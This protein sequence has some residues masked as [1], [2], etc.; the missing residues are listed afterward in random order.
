MSPRVLC[1][2]GDPELRATVREL[3]EASGF[4]VDESATALAGIERALTLPPDLVLADFHLPDIEGYQLATRLKQ[5]RSLARIPFVAVGTGAAEHDVA[6]AA[7][8]DGFIQQPI[9][10][11]RFVAEV[12]AFLAGKREQLDEQGE[13]AN[14]RTLSA[15][16]AARLERAVA[17]ASD[18][19]ARLDRSDKLKRAFIHNLAHELSTPLTPLAGY[20]KILQSGK[21]GALSDQQ[22]KILDSTL[23]AVGRLTRI[24][25]NLSDFASLQAGESAILQSAVDPDQLAEEVVAELRAAIKESRLNVTVVRSGGGPVHADARKLRQALANLVGNAVKFSP[26]GGEV[27]VEVARLGE[28]LRFSIYDQGPGIRGPDAANVFEPFFHATRKGDARAPG[29]GLGLPV[30][31]RIAEA[32]GG[33]VLL[34]SPPRTQPPGSPRHF[35]GTKMVL[36]IPAQPREAPPARVSG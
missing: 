32:H 31:R 22:R 33:Q 8:C 9:E 26:H 14:L 21:L 6:I 17:G 10:R 30:A 2:E 18:A 4:A 15:G 36:E 11:D 13:R 1:I 19:A 27:L 23:A 16:L 20:L 34:E 3:L 7:G 24:V 25:D 29:S 35:T 5:E 12:R 28:K